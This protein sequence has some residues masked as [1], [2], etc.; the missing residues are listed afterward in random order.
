MNNPIKFHKVELTGPTTN[1]IYIAIGTQGQ[2]NDWAIKEAAIY[3]CSYT[4]V[5]RGFQICMDCLQDIASGAKLIN[6]CNE[7]EY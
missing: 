6:L 5:T 1:Q 3:G 7:Y 2:V 4:H